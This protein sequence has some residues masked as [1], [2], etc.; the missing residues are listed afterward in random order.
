MRRPAAKKTPPTDSRRTWVPVERTAYGIVRVMK[1]RHE[2]RLGYYDDDASRGV[3][4]VYLDGAPAWGQA[5][6][7]IYRSWLRKATPREERRYA[8]LSENEVA[9]ARTR[10]LLRDHMKG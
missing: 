2:G 1:G 8:D 3:A 9:V 10:K 6:E 5:Y 4:I 7:C